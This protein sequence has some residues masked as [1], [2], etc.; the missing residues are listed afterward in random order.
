MKHRNFVQNII[1]FLSVSIFCLLLLAFLLFNA[2]RF[3]S[4]LKAAWNQEG[5]AQDKLMKVESKF[6]ENIKGRHYFIDLYGIALNA[7][8]QKI[9]GN[10]DF[11]KDNHNIVQHFTRNYDYSRFL[12]SILDLNAYAKENGASLVYITLPDKTKYLPIANEYVFD[13]QQS[14]KVGNSLNGDI[15]CIELENLMKNDEAAPSYDQFYFKTDVHCT[16]YGEFWMLKELV[17]HLEE[18]C[19]ISFPNKE[20]VLNLENYTINS[21]EFLGNTARSAGK[22]FVGTDQFEIYKP[23]FETNLTLYNPFASETKTGDF[24]SVILNGYENGTDISEYTYWVTNYGRFTSPHYEYINHN[25]PDDAPNILVVSDSIFMRGFSY[26]AL[27]CQK[28]T[29]LD[30][31]Y[32]DEMEYLAGELGAEHYDAIVVVGTSVH[33]FNTSFSAPNTLSALPTTTMISQEKY[34][35]WIANQGICLDTCND[36]RLEGSETVPIDPAAASIKLY[37]WAADFHH[38][39][40]FQA[41]YLQVGDILLKC[42]YGI[43]RTS[44][45]DH[46]KKDSLLKTGFQVKVPAEYLYDGA[47]TEVSFIGVSADGK[48]VYTPVTYQL[49][50]T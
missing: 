19:K 15:D 48:Y 33:F 10:L 39:A 28:V 16:T 3:S 26:L 35:E 40:P 8:Q 18:S 7:L 21:Y 50:Y 13:G 25:A 36:V 34:G 9:V 42:D 22:Y 49:S 47:V 27:A 12:K 1:N 46:F 2:G 14:K 20:K 31:R 29:V 38:D 4:V 5:N 44:V 23:N 32:F 17:N 41:L 30:P 37:G 11:V 45:V 43:E 24:D 6:Q